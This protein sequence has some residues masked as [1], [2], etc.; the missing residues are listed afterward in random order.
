MLHGVLEKM[1]ECE[2]DPHSIHVVHAENAIR[3]NI[4]VPYWADFMAL[5]TVRT[6][7]AL[8]EAGNYLLTA[9]VFHGLAA[10]FGFCACVQG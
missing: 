1:N 10:D 2:T 6:K 4:C 8:T 9:S 5:L 7:S 3:P